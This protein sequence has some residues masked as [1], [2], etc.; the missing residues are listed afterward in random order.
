[1]PRPVATLAGCVLVGAS[2][3]LLAVPGASAVG[4]DFAA[5]R[6]A[7]A[8]QGLLGLSSVL[9]APVDPVATTIW[10]PEEF[11]ELW[12][13][14]LT[15]RIVGLGA[16]LMLGVYRICMGVVDL[17][18]APLPMMPVSP[19]LRFAFSPDLVHDREEDPEWL[20]D[21]DGWGED[22][23]SWGH[24]LGVIACFPWKGSAAAQAE[25]E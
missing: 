12:G 10:P 3:L 5:Y 2:A 24:R 8:N 17:V 14:P 16:G 22:A 13:A 11:D 4:E 15:N 9:S 21:M 7:T 20:C 18:A 23:R 6:T 1:M 25:E 19:K